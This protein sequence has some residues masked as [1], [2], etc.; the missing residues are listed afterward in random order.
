MAHAKWLKDHETY[1]GLSHEDASNLGEFCADQEFGRGDAL[2]EEGDSSRS[3]TFFLKSGTAKVVTGSGTHEKVLR[4]HRPG[5]FFGEMAMIDSSQK[6]SAS[7]IATTPCATLYLSQPQY[8]RLKRT[9][10]TT[11]FRL[12]E[13]F[14]KAMAARLREKSK[15]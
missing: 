10:P 5:D 3:G 12:H 9:H 13:I 1:R 8:E 6:R 15:K 7:V 2:I 14:L 11:V 4:L